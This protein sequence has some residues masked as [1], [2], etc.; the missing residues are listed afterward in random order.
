MKN[1]PTERTC[2]N[3]ANYIEVLRQ[4]CMKGGTVEDDEAVSCRGY[5]NRSAMLQ[6]GY[7]RRKR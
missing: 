6:E 4:C 3:C 2:P 5:C 1:V 7:L